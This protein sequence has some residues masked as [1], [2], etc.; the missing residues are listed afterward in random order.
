[1]S[2][3]ILDL[4]QA[5][6]DVKDVDRSVIF[7]AVEAA[8]VM[9]TRKRHGGKLDAR[10]SIHRDTGDYDTFRIWHVVADESVSEIENPHAELTLSE[11][12]Q[13]DPEAKVGGIVEQSMESVKLDRIGAQTARQ[14]M[15]QKVREAERR[16][17][18]EAYEKRKGE[19]ITGPVRRVTR[20]C[21]FVGLGMG[22]NADAVVPREELLPRDVFRVGD[23]LRGVLFKVDAE[24][25]GAQLFVSRTQKDFLIELFKIEVPEISEQLI[26]IKGAARDPGVRA[27]IA[28]KTNDKRIDPVGACV[29]MRGSRVQAV[30]S[31]LGGERIDIV[32]WDDNPA[33][34]ALSAMAPAEVSSIVV[35]EEA[36]TIDVAVSTSQLSQAIGKGGQNV[37]LVAE[38]TGWNVNIMSEEDATKKGEA[39]VQKV[40][41]M[42]SEELGVDEELAALL[43]KEGF[44][45]VEEVGYIAEEELVALDG[46]DEELAKQLQERAK[47]VMLTE[48]IAGEEK[49]K[50][51]D[52]LLALEGMDLHLA[53]AL[54]D[55]GIVTQEDLAEQ[56][57]DDLLEIAD[58][59]RERAGALIMA[60]RAPWFEDLSSDHS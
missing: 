51:A 43:A 13:Y 6:S 11:A 29:G 16:R 41:D 45:T 21:I 5:L 26:E 33:Q 18:A 49:V 1:M 4:V 23:R 53:Q 56:A 44:S 52:D 55:K 40:K 25:K 14:V 12:Q 58:L 46:V 47:D 48:A 8:L 39:E 34:L 3:E 31:E 57:V 19:I 7:E 59:D 38:L 32:L 20:D 30:S 36:N 50:P 9:A 35:D 17:I 60:A 54:A 15:I 42:F 22:S 27:K 37:R 24:A 2:K 10:V 28:V